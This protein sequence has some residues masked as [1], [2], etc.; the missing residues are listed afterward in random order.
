MKNILIGI[1]SSISAYKIYELIRLFKKANYNVKTV[2]S[3]N[4]LNFI[5]PLVLETLSENEC[6]YNQFV[7]RTNVE[8]IHLVDWADCFLI[9][10]VSA[11]T[12]S[13]IE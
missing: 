8:H 1:T 4:A 9:A 2:I 7:P 12:I 11:N 10:P 5:S 13:K 3:D 6:Y